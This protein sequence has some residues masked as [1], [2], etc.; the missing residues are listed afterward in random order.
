MFS[1][2]SSTNL[3]L[4]FLLASQ[5]RKHVTFN[6]AIVSI[7][8]LLMLAV[9]SRNL[10]L[11]PTSPTEGDR[12]IIA[13]NPS[14]EWA[15]NVGKIAAYNNLGWVFYP[16]KAGFICYVA[17]ENAVI[18]FDG[19]EW[20]HL[21]LTPAD[22]Q[23]LATI[24]IGTNADTNNPFALK[25]NN[26]L[27]A[28]K[29]TTE[30]GSGDIRIKLSKEAQ[31]KTSSFIFQNNWSG[32]AEF[33]LIGND[34]FTL[35]ISN[36]GTD[37]YEVIRVSNNTGAVRVKSLEHNT[38]KPMYSM[39]P[40][41]YS[42]LGTGQVELYRCDETCG[43]TPRQTTISSVTNDVITLNGTVAGQFFNDG[44]ENVAY[45][46]VW[47]ISKSPAQSAW[48]KRKPTSDKLQVT[49]ATHISSWS[50]SEILQ[51]GE[52]GTSDAKDL[53]SFTLDISPILIANFG[54][55]FRQAGVVLGANMATG[56]TAGDRIG[57]T[58]TGLGGTAITLPGG[59]QVAGVAA[60]GGTAIV[61]C[62][63]LSTISNSNLLRIQENIANTAGVR[64]VRLTTIMG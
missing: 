58:P 40:I 35:K 52:D 1:S 57:Y 60:P 7:D 24:G 23:N 62:S 43:Q 4:P 39:L 12:Y 55:A 11:P 45:L 25:A 46:R 5:A 8:N 48:V 27:F 63:E 47:N 61:S 13:A 33:G 30:D 34:D 18:F 21:S 28:A 15:S 22:F 56:G 36:N 49:D 6:E 26:A 32:R 2:D 51:I 53:R 20:K 54:S 31:G 42:M 19:T 38:G 50:N 17:D 59:V 64:L 14:G 3:N 41:S 37:F 44:M 16:P 10:A 29:P 9:K